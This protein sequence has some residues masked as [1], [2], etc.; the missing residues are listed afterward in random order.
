M[1]RTALCIARHELRHA[2]R[3]RTLLTLAVVV[4]LLLIGAGVVGHARQSADVAQRARFQ[5][6]VGEQ[7]RAQP[8]RHPH[9]VSHYGYL[10]FRPRSPLGFFDSGLERFTGTSI[11][12][13]AHRQNSANF[14]DVGQDSGTRRFGD[15]TMALVLQMIVPLLLFATAGVSVARERETGTLALVLSQSASWGAFLLGKICGS[16]VIVACVVLPGV[17]LVAVWIGSGSLDLWGLDVTAR[18][19]LLA[20][21]SAAYLLACTVL[22]VLVSSWHR[23]NRGALVT[24]VTLWLALWV[25]VPRALPS[26]AASFYPLPSRAAFEA[27]VERHVRTL[28]DSHNPDDPTFAGLRVRTLAQYGATRVE[29]LPFNYNGVVMSESEKMTAAAYREHTDRLLHTHRQQ[30]HLVGV[31]GF[32][33]PYIAM[34]NLSMALA[35]VDFSHAIDFERQAEEYRFGLV[36]YLNE[37]HTNR[38]AFAQDRYTGAGEN[39]AP[40]R[41]RISH[42]HWQS[43]PAAEYRAPTLRWAIGQQPL[44]VAALVWWIAGMTIAVIGVTRRSARL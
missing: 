2:W 9:R 29:E 44:S 6:M 14:S 23:T 36:Q 41:K 25:V 19:A 32:V 7:W 13:E 5:A 20:V 22:A 18:A 3:S 8:D 21:S 4:T 30:N 15:L 33:S 16:F 43:A 37:L 12:L 40:T 11:F 31:A 1:I 10:L 42:E 38:V 26:L 24:L 28:G 35:G 27:D 34:R 39:G 17:M